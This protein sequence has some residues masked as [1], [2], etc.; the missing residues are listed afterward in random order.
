MDV[1]A[2]AVFFSKKLK[3]VT[4]SHSHHPELVADYLPSFNV[5]DNR[6]TKNKDNLLVFTINPHMT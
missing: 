3:S 6:H 2:T 5:C 4:T 1:L